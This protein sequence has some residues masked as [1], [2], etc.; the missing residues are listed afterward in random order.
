M[1]ER[2]ATTRIDVPLVGTITVEGE[3]PIRVYAKNISHEGAY[4]WGTATPPIGAQVRID[5]KS[6]SEL[7][8]FEFSMEAVGTVTRVDPP[9]E[10]KTGFA[11][12]FEEILDANRAVV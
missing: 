12:N 7:Q 1:D 10:G 9:E 8:Q 11:V 3:D 5:L 6:S 2:R 4:L